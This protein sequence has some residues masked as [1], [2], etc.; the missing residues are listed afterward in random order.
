MKAKTLIYL[1]AIGLGWISTSLSALSDQARP[2]PKKIEI[3]NSSVMI[4]S[5]RHQSSIRSDTSLT[6]LAE[7]ISSV[8]QEA[9]SYGFAAKSEEAKS[10]IIGTLYSESLAYLRGGNLDLASKRLT[11]IEKE[12][13]NR[14]IPGSLYNLISSLIN[15]VDTKRYTP[16]ARAE[17]LSLFQPFYEDYAKSQGEDKLVLFRAGCWL[18]DMSLTAAAGDTYLLKQPKTIQYFITEMKRLDAPK[19]VLNALDEMARISS[20]KEMSDNDAKEI[21]KLMKKIQTLLL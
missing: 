12:F 4:N 7:G 15:I 5:Y 1:T 10:F 18:E 9:V 11:T 14:Q 8:G 19:G 17:F 20:Q 21:L 3:K 6:A 2:I 16:E 13:V